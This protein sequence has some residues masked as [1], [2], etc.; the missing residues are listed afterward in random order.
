M[1]KTVKNLWDPGN[2]TIA[3][4]IHKIVNAMPEHNHVIINDLILP[5]KTVNPTN[6]L[7]NTV[8]IL[9]RNNC[10]VSFAFDSDGDRICIITNKGKILSS[11][12]TLMMIQHIKNSKDNVV[13]IDVK[14]SNKVANMVKNSGGKC[15][16]F[17]TGHSLIKRKM[18]ETKAIIAGEGS[19]HIFFREKGYDDGLYAAIK[20]I[21]I[22][23][24]TN[25]QEISSKMPSIYS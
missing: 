22:L 6:N 11:S 25:W 10:D 12:H 14:I 4:I 24:R 23:S 3:V 5:D 15:I 21:K 9:K 7:L 1:C 17:P 13:I 8:E 20:F 19:G 18:K 2:A 16:T